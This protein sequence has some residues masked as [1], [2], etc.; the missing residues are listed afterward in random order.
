MST[1]INR[2]NKRGKMYPEQE[3]ITSALK[4]LEENEDCNLTICNLQKKRSEV[5]QPPYTQPC[6]SNLN[7]LYFRE[8]VIKVMFK[9]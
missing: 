1:Q 8:S 6:G 4:F 7:V 5:M 3:V 2:N 9:F